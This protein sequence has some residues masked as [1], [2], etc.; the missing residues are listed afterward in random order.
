MNPFFQSY[1]T[2]YFAIAGR[3]WPI[4]VANAATPLLGLANTTVIGRPGEFAASGAIA[5]GVARFQF[6]VLNLWLP[7]DGNKTGLVAQAVSLG[8]LYQRLRRSIGETR[9]LIR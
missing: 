5:P 2:T 1:K 9:P 8:V 6:C 7:P 3:V 4:V